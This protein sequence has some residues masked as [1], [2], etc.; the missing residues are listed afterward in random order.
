MVEIFTLLVTLCGPPFIC[1]NVRFTPTQVAFTR[2]ET[3]TNVKFE[4]CVIVVSNQQWRCVNIEGPA[5]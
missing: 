3:V 2:R 5:S 1:D 4:R